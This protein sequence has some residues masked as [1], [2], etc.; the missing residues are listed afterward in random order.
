MGAIHSD[1]T[2]PV[3]TTAVEIVPANNRRNYL[4]IVNIGAETVY[5][6]HGA[7]PT[8]ATDGW[9]LEANFEKEWD[10]LATVPVEQIQAI[11]AS[12]ST[13]IYVEVA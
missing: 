8:G 5:I 13:T 11:T 2:V 9:P 3:S 10:N 7:V 6:R 12:G 1:S 4:R